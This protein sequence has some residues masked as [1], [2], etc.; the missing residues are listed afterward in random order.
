MNAITIVAAM[1]FAAPGDVPPKV[2]DAIGKGVAFLKKNA[3]SQRQSG[4]TALLALALMKSGETPADPVVSKL[5]AKLRRTVVDGVYRS[6]R[7]SSGP[8]NYEAPLVLM[9]LATADANKHQPE[10]AAIAKYILGKQTP[11]GAWDYGGAEGGTGDTSMTQYA[12]LG[13]WESTAAG[14]K[15]PLDVWDRALHWLVT[16]QDP[17]G[18]FAYHPTK[19]DGEGRVRQQEVTHTMG[20]GGSATVLICRSQLP[21]PTK[22]KAGRVSKQAAT[23][24]L[25]IPV[26]KEKEKVEYEFK[27]TAAKAEESV[28]LANK[29]MSANFGAV[30]RVTGHGGAYYFLYALER[31]AELAKLKEVGKSSWYDDGADFCVKQQ[32]DDGS[33]VNKYEPI[34]DTSFALLFLGRSTRKTLSRI[35]ITMLG[36]GTMLGGR[37]LPDPGSDVGGLAGR[38]K[39]RYRQALK[40]PVDSLLESLDDPDVTALD[41]SAATLE[42]STTDEV[43]GALKGNLAALRRVAKKGKS[44]ANRQAALTALARSGDYRV[45]PILIGA[46]ADPE[47][48]VYRA[49]RD[50]LAFLSRRPDAFGLPESG[51]SEDQLSRGAAQ[52]AAWFTMLHLMID[53]V[54]E[55]ED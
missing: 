13:L 36:Q 3:E 15:V 12:I 9:A 42:V 32:K 49:A 24:D 4:E 25:L 2:Q 33:W 52:A 28:A 7:G 39:A 48:I 37:G 10:I 47:P 43:A 50:G 27:V 54:Q 19:P 55:F 31:Y 44:P 16:R 1:A 35:Q 14:F 5:V 18:G 20:A 17:G 46:L 30:D 8:D 11:M 38:R 53:P 29:W 6:D 26:E 22:F 40:T 21:F 41:G 45:A 34:I 51:P 23:S